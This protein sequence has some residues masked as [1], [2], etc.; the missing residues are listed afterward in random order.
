MCS[1]RATRTGAIAQ[2]ADTI[3]LGTYDIG[4]AV[5]MDKHPVVR[6]PII[7]RNWL[8]RSGME[9]GI[10]TTKFFGMK[11]NRY[12]HDHGISQHPGAGGGQELPQR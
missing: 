7:P 5:G 2:T 11:A 4:I 10:L 8:C 3:R 12:I 1:T 6:S 9:N